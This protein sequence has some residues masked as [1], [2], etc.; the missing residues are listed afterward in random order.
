MA[1]LDESANVSYIGYIRDVQR[2]VD[3]FVE[4]LNKSKYGLRKT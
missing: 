3:S 2:R 4:S 1:K